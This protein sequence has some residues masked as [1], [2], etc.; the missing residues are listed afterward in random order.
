MRV[1]THYMSF[2]LVLTCVG[3]VIKR[4]VFILDDIIVF[5]TDVY[6]IYCG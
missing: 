3:K 1:A 6:M 4:V 2:V 5:P